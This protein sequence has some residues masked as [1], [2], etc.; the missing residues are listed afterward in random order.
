M[1]R[2]VLSC[3]AVNEKIDV[4]YG[5]RKLERYAHAHVTT[6]F[7][8]TIVPLRVGHRLDAALDLLLEQAPDLVGISTFLWNVRENLELARAIKER[9]PQTVVVLGGP[10]VSDP[11]WDVLALSDRVDLV[12][13]G[14]G[15]ATFAEL[16]DAW[17]QA[18][19]L[20][21]PTIAGTSYRRGG[22][23]VH[24]P[25][26]PPLGDL[27]AIPSIYDGFEARPDVLYGLETT[28]GCYLRCGYCS[29][30]GVPFR[31][32]SIDYVLR[33]L[34]FIAAAGVRSLNILDSSFTFDPR[35]TIPIVRRL[36]D[37]GIRYICCGGAEE[38][39]GELAD[40]LLATGLQ[41]IEFGLQAT[42]AEALRLMDRRLHKERFAEGIGGL[43]SRC[44]GSDV[45]VTI[46]VIAGLPGDDLAS[47][48]E[49]LDFAY[50]LRPHSVAAFPFQLLPATRF[51]H[52]A[53][54]LGIRAVPVAATTL[55]D[56]GRYRLHR[57]GQ[58]TQTATFAAAEIEAARRLCMLNA[59]VLQAH[60]TPL[61]YRVL[62]VER[63]SFSTWLER[64]AALFPP[65]FYERLEGMGDDPSLRG[66]VW[67]E[68]RRAL[69]DYAAAAVTP[70]VG[71][72]MAERFP[73]LRGAAAHA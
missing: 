19:A 14:E 34:D 59:L 42:S 18:G 38:L 17:L 16:L 49:T 20:R 6:P 46:D 3:P 37:H 32:H 33:E 60:L 41:K 48:R 44:R 2:V 25:D 65:G 73:E 61:V 53:E 31:R 23:G 39:T 28:R 24:N 27:D 35:R 66:Q 11:A 54:E 29:M 4:T 63:L 64:L 47:F 10:Q 5:L 55:G 72:L 13:R 51:F 56:H 21:A 9:A 71:D 12:V 70:Q 68:L 15:E 69:A 8:S 52:R 58:V 43:L 22:V 1:K 36:R 50:S 62:D 7:A 30:G 45:E 26:R 40:E 57:Y 67:S